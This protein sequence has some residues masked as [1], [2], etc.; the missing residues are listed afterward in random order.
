M[1][2][3]NEERCW[4]C[5][6]VTNEGHTEAVSAKGNLSAF[7]LMPKRKKAGV[8]WAVLFDFKS[9]TML[10]CEAFVKQGVVQGC[11]SSVPRRQWSAWSTEAA[12]VTA[13][14][15]AL[16]TGAIYN[17]FIETTA[18]NTPHRFGAECNT[19]LLDFLEKMGI[20]VL[21]EAWKLAEETED[22]A[23]V[24]V[25]DKDVRDVIDALRMCYK[26]KWQS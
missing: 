23:D 3:P 6:L 10:R 14:D 20:P 18:R 13:Y 21:D 22:G 15:G 1:A 25:V 26:K 2:R 17:A 12:A 24:T 4:V 16:S 8:H 11:L 9:G 7:S 5:L 19:W